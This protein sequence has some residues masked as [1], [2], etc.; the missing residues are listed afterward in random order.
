M[1]TRT[2]VS[3]TLPTSGA[4]AAVYH[5]DISPGDVNPFVILVGNPER[6]RRMA[7][8]LDRVDVERAH[9]EFVTISGRHD[10]LPVTFC[11]TGIGC[12]NTEIALIELAQ[13]ADNLTL[14]RAGTCGALHEAIDL[15]DLVVT[16]GAMRL[17]NTSLAYVDPGYPA[18]SHHEVVGALVQAA[19]REKAP[20]HVG[21]TATASGFYG[22]QGRS[23]PGFPAK[24]PELPARLAAQGVL[25]FEMEASTLLTLASLRGF[26]AGV[27]C[28]VFASRTRDRFMPEEERRSAEDRC[29]R[30]ALGGLHALAAVNR[31][32]K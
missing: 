11:G 8:L 15:G 28:T 2:R 29:I 1:K 22:A 30:V 5:L 26:R 7:S 25:N 27:V 3:A 31:R 32:S 19:A 4:R 16:S 17:E 6:A 9:R 12:D 18:V 23:V 20:C 10:G 14:I 13:V 21:I 24:D